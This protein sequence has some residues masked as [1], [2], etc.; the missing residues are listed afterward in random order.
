MPPRI[1]RDNAT[2][3]AEY[4]NLSSGDI[5]VGRVRIRTGEEHLLLDLAA[6]RVILV[7]SAVSQLCSRSKVFQSRILAGYMVP[8]TAAVYNRH[9]ALALISEYG[10]RGVGR[11][12]CKLDRA[13]GGQ[14]IL[15]L[16]SIE[17]V[18]SNAVLGM[19]RFPFVVQ[20]FIAGC[21]DVRVVMLGSLV[22][23]YSRHNPH[24]FRQ[25]LHCGGSSSAYALAEAQIALCREVMDRGG[26]PYAHVD[27][28]LDPDGSTWLSEINLRGGLRGA[29]LSQQDYLHAIEEIHAGILAGISEEAERMEGQGAG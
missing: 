19:L 26:F 6:R 23:A 14:G 9:D 2:L 15:L 18:Y 7:P 10:R 16:N 24:N 21:E 29:T 5:V 22:E 1:V 17:E 25:N 4:D 28:L 13:N 20:P 3:V 11:V 8:G 12:V 27:L